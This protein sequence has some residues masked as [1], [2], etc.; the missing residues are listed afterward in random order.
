[1]QGGG[2]NDGGRYVSTIRTSSTHGGVWLLTVRFLC[3]A[4]VMRSDFLCYPLLGIV[5]RL[6]A[7][8]PLI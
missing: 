8:I 1:M 7:C 5:M 4:T 2:A 6:M 3:P